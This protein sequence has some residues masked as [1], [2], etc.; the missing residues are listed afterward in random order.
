VTALADDVTQFAAKRRQ[1]GD[2][3]LDLLDMGPGDLVDGGAI[4]V[5][6]AGEAEEAPDSIEREAQLTAASDNPSLAK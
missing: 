2:F 5:F 4:P 3:A 6:P 1:I